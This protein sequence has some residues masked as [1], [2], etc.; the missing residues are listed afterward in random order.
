MP[1]EELDNTATV[2]SEPTS[3][4]DNTEL[5][6]YEVVTLN[7]NSPKAPI[8]GTSYYFVLDKNAE[9]DTYTLFHIFTFRTFELSYEKVHASVVKNTWTYTPERTVQILKQKISQQTKKNAVTPEISNLLKH[10]E[11]LCVP[12]G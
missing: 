4:I 2:A 5:A 6:Q 7:I 3:V 1:Q 8:V 10:Y 11:E 12:Q 9:N